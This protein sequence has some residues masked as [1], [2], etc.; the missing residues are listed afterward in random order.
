MLNFVS[1]FSHV[2]KIPFKTYPHFVRVTAETAL[3][4]VLSIL[5]SCIPGRSF[6]EYAESLSWCQSSMDVNDVLIFW[7]L[8]PTLQR[9]ATLS[10]GNHLME[11]NYVPASM[12][13]FFLGQPF[14]EAMIHV[15]DLDFN[16]LPNAKLKEKALIS[17]KDFKSIFCAAIKENSRYVRQYPANNLEVVQ[18]QLESTFRLNSNPRIFDHDRPKTKVL[19][20]YCGPITFAKDESDFFI[21][22]FTEPEFSFGRVYRSAVW[23]VVTAR[24]E[25]CVDPTSRAEML[26]H[27]EGQI[28]SHDPFLPPDI[29]KYCS[30]GLRL[31]AQPLSFPTPHSISGI[32]EKAFDY[33]MH[34]VYHLPQSEFQNLIQAVV[35]IKALSS[36]LGFPTEGVSQYIHPGFG[37][38]EVTV[39]STGDRRNHV[40]TSRLLQVTEFGNFVVKS[41]MP[42]AKKSHLHGVEFFGTHEEMI[43]QTMGASWFFQSFLYSHQQNAF[44]MK[45]LNF[46]NFQGTSMNYLGKYRD[47]QKVVVPAISAQFLR[48]DSPIPLMSISLSEDIQKKLAELNSALQMAADLENRYHYNIFGQ[49]CVSCHATQSHR[50]IIETRLQ[51]SQS[52]SPLTPQGYLPSTRQMAIDGVTLERDFKRFADGILVNQPLSGR[53]ER[54]YEFF[55]LRG[56]VLPFQN[57]NN[58]IENPIFRKDYVLRQAGY[59]EFLPM[60]SQRSI[61]ES[62]FNAAFLN[63]RVDLSTFRPDTRRPLA[64]LRE[65]S[66]E[67]FKFQ[68][69]ERER[70]MT[71]L[72]SLIALRRKKNMHTIPRTSFLESL[73]DGQFDFKKYT[74]FKD[75][76]DCGYAN[77]AINFKAAEQVNQDDVFDESEPS[78]A[79]DLF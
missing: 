19:D 25:F 77:S 7:P 40:D 64:H 50:S 52:L 59:F 9:E 55:R 74:G 79:Q 18:R 24:I 70:F 4:S 69:R 29:K 22:D 75:W 15:T 31:V 21:P 35:N 38:Q 58:A 62:G 51:N 65:Y 10:F 2:K 73:R 61:N 72:T 23:R 48:K 68:K 8:I 56:V 20:A 6:S 1:R 12:W 14:E 60:I 36:E 49:T 17:E 13:Q 43:S 67:R 5:L 41:L 26:L 46:I 30:P 57:L 28:T 63:K 34:F 76:E 33:A 47:P 44:Q 27:G 45:N 11:R 3:L 42:F 16:D 54:T 32:G 78:S 39:G 66:L 53:A 37:A 71:C